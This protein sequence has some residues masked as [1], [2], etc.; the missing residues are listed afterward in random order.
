LNAT[1]PPRSPPPPVR[2][3]PE[4]KTR[5]IP[6]T[7]SLHYMSKNL[8]FSHTCSKAEKHKRPYSTRPH[9]K[10]KTISFHR[11]SKDHPVP[12]FSNTQRFHELQRSKGPEPGAYNL[13]NGWLFDETKAI[14]PYSHQSVFKESTGPAIGRASFETNTAPDLGL[15]KSHYVHTVKHDLDKRIEGYKQI[16]QVEHTHTHTHTLTRT[17]K[18]THTHAHTHTHTHTHTNKHTITFS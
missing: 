8:P 11:P 9:I 17:H 2:T 6:T 15:G 1:G 7:R 14:N 16:P 5:N 3:V 4:P 10:T 12:F 13:P 18:H